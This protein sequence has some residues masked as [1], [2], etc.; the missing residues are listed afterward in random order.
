MATNLFTN[1]WKVFTNSSTTGAPAPAAAPAAPAPAA[2]PAAPDPLDAMAALW[3][4]DPNKP[5]PVDP[6][7]GS[8][9]NPDNKKIADAAATVDFMAGID[10][11][12]LA[13]A[14]D[15]DNPAGLIN[16]MNAVAQKTLATA[17]QIGAATVDQGLQR[18]NQRLAQALP[19]RIKQ[20]QVNQQESENP[21]LAHEAAQP[22]V[23]M[24]RNQIAAQNPHLSPDAINKQAEQTLLG[25]AQAVTG[26]EDAG[27]RQG[28]L[29]QSR[30]AQ[31]QGTDWL[32]WGG[33]DE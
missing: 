3:K 32:K 11:T 14:Q 5:A 8:V 18:N 20:V 22:M 9:I 21:A 24:V 33:V 30:Q 16:L 17:T 13:A 2:A 27:F 1:A 12:L 26:T 25:F 6:L 23:R 28:G 29:P 19:D 15:R 4:N 10:P 7:A 31:S